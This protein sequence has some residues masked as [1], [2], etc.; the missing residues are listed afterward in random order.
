MN[1]TMPQLAH[2]FNILS[3]LWRCMEMR[4]WMENK[5]CSQVVVCLLEWIKGQN[6]LLQHAA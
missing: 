2:A 6:C 3:A 5:F 1:Q 4:Y